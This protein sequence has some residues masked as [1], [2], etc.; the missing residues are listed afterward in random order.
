MVTVFPPK[1]TE[2]EVD[3]DGLTVWLF[4]TEDAEVVGLC[5][6]VGPGAGL[7][8]GVQAKMKMSIV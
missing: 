1:E 3:E 7:A 5:V 6:W 8:L 2:D 4:G